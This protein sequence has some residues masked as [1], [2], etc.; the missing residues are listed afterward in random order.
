MKY[1]MNPNDYNRQSVQIL[2]RPEP[3]G[4]L[5]PDRSVKP[6]LVYEYIR[7]KAQAKAAANN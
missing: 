7:T 4:K 6:V 1:R 5:L 3:Y 2:R